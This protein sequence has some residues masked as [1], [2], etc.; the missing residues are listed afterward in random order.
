MVKA[1]CVR[2]PKGV[3][4]ETI[5]KEFVFGIRAL[6]G[7]RNKDPE[8]Y[9]L[10]VY[11]HL[12]EGRVENRLEKNHPQY[13]QP[14]SNPALPVFGSLVYCESSALYPAATEAGSEPAF[15]WRE[16]GKPFRKNHP[17][18]TRPRF[19]P[20]SPPSSV[21]WLNSTGALANYA[22]EAGRR[23]QESGQRLSCQIAW[24][25]G[26]KRVRGPARFIPRAQREEMRVM[27]LSII[28]QGGI[29][30]ASCV[31]NH[32]K[33]TTRSTLSW[34]SNHDLSISGQLDC[35][36][37]TS[38]S[39]SVPLSVKEGFCNQMNLCRDQGLNPAPPAQKSD[40]LPLDSQVT[41]L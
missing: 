35:M 20:R 1:S 5:S 15:A 33:E 8:R 25:K 32:L 3:Q 10:P 13:T 22:T 6:N 31:G 30:L 41:P 36:S 18:F 39:S 4:E 40:T 17:Q 21:V 34:D 27:M 23:G 37:L 12:H 19:E 2:L 38:S 7:V 14:G 26:C 29:S 16:S 28:R 9:H 24:D 11:L